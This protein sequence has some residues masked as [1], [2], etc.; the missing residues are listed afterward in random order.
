MI[1]FKKTFKFTNQKQKKETSYEFKGYG[2]TLQPATLLLINSAA[3]TALGFP[4]S[5]GLEI[6][7]KQKITC[8]KDC[9]QI[10]MH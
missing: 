10:S 1:K 8:Q 3:T 6:K 9:A 4:I 5:F 2:V 7:G